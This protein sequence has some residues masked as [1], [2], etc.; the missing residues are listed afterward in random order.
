MNFFK[1]KQQVDLADLDYNSTDNS[2]EKNNRF[3]ELLDTLKLNKHYRLERKIAYIGTAS[4]FLIAG[5]GWSTVN[6][7]SYQHEQTLKTVSYNTEISF[8]KTANVDMT[9]NN[10][11]LTTNRKRAYITF[12]FSNMDNLS[13]RAKNYYTFIQSAQGVTEPMS[14]HAS[15]QFILF[16]NTGNGCF[17]I[18]TPDKISNEPIT[19]ILRNDKNLRDPDSIAT[20]NNSASSDVLGDYAKKYDLLYFKV[21]LGARNV[22]KVSHL[23]GDINGEKLYSKFFAQPQRDD[24]EQLNKSYLKRIKSAEA[25]VKELRY[26]LSKAGY[27][28][29]DNPRWLNDDWRP[30]D[31]INSETGLL[32]NGLGSSAVLSDGS[33]NDPDNISYPNDLDRE[34][35]NGTLLTNPTSDSDAS[36]YSKL[37]D[38]WNSIKQLKRK[39]YVNN[40]KSLAKINAEQ[41]EQKTAVSIGSPSRFVQSSPVKVKT[42]L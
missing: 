5:L 38:Y 16:G 21:N 17:V 7:L 8:T 14:Y 40:N 36:T 1:K 32:E 10:V 42:I 11:Y 24:V 13:V 37:Q 25:Q 23:D 18:D 12:S 33:I 26:R 4:F 35:N 20:A 30:Y 6:A 3:A 39:I 34:D 28:L 22:D 9:I 31:S 19:I 2:T 41:R 29:P 27:V 15:G